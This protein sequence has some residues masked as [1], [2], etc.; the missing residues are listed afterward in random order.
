ME[1]RVAIAG[2][3]MIGSYLYRLLEGQGMKPDIYGDTAGHA[4]CGINPCAWGSTSSFRQHVSAAGLDPE[5]YVFK[6]FRVV[7]F[8]GVD[9]RAHL[10][11]FDKPRLINDLLKGVKVLAR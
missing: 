11:T 1:G 6:D 7:N 4:T 2:A 5:Q 3:G 8:E 10:L 9:M